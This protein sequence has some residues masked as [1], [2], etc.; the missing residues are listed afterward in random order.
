MG[1]VIKAEQQYSSAV[2]LAKSDSG[3]TINSSNYGNS[4]ERPEENR[5]QM[6]NMKECEESTLGA[7]KMGTGQRMRERRCGDW[8]EKKKVVEKKEWEVKRG[9]MNTS[10]KLQFFPYLLMFLLLFYFIQ[11][12]PNCTTISF[13]PPPQGLQTI[14]V[15]FFAFHMLCLCSFCVSNHSL[16]VYHVLVSPEKEEIN[17]KNLEYKPCF[18]LHATT[19]NKQKN[20]KE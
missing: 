4:R 14:Q 1:Q 12:W 7:G 16:G 19:E 18:Q 5:G 13:P 8:M 17:H 9:E 2:Q 3:I 15:L 6:R 10:L 11:Y 20:N